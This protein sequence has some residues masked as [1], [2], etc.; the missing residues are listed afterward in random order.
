MTAKFTIT[1]ENNIDEIEQKVNDIGQIRG[2]TR[3]WKDIVTVFDVKTNEADTVPVSQISIYN[4]RL[5]LDGMRY[6][7]LY[8]LSC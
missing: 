7:I 6:R 5:I 4:H 2:V 1:P 3:D 8:M